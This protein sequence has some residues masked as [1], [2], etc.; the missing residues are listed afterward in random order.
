MIAQQKILRVFRLIKFLKSKPR[1]GIEELS[2]KLE[3]SERTVF[4]YFNL[5]EEIGF[6]L[7]L[8]FNKKYF[9]VSDIEEDSLNFTNEEIQ[10]LNTS[11]GLLDSKSSFKNLILEKLKHH[12]EIN[13]FGADLLKADHAKKVETCRQSLEKN[14]RIELVNYYS[15]NSQTSENRVVELIGFDENF[16]SIRV[17]DIRNPEIIKTF[18]LNR[19]EKVELM[20][21]NPQKYTV[22]KVIRQ[23]DPFNFSGDQEIDLQLILSHNTKVLIGEQ[24]SRIKPYINKRGQNSFD[25]K[26]KIYNLEP[27]KRFVL[28]NLDGVKVIKPQSLKEEVKNFYE[29]YIN[30]L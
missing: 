10:L 14:C 9:I 15:L 23:K 27:V 16:E 8:D 1:L 2:E 11:I 7:D 28:A 22:G 6:E 17:V 30:N 12:T 24:Y 25:L 29:K 5:L 3:S 13:H 19:C 4:R 21:E 26:V 20:E 18:K